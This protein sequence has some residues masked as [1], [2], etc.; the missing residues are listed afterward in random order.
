MEH[1]DV[2]RINI[3]SVQSHAARRD[4]RA[5]DQVI[6]AIKT[7]QQRCFPATGRPNEGSDS[8]RRD[9]Q[10]HIEKNLMRAI[11]KIDISDIDHDRLARLGFGWFLQLQRRG[12]MCYFLVLRYYPERSPLVSSRRSRERR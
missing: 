8:S 2:R 9:L 10:V 7:A 3:M 6:H 12:R 5:V 1:V 4:S 11:T